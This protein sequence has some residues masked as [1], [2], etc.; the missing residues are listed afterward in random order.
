MCCCCCGRRC[1]SG[2]PGRVSSVAA[3]LEAIR[4]MYGQR[5]TRQTVPPGREVPEDYAMGHYEV[6][7]ST[8]MSDPWV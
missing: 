3:R 7:Y 4:I 5:K 6:T 8:F 2:A 1:G